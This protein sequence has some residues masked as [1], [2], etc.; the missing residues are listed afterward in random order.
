MVFLTKIFLVSALALAKYPLLESVASR[1]STADTIKMDVVKITRLKLLGKER[2]SEGQILVKK[3]GRLRWDTS[4][5]NKA[6]VLL[7]GKTI[8]LVDYPIDPEDKITVLKAANPKKSQPQTVVAFLLGRGHI[9]K[10][11][12]VEGKPKLE[13][14]VASYKLK[15][16]RSETQLKNLFIRISEN[17]KT[18]THMI[19]ED[20]LDNETEL[21]FKNIE[22]NLP[23]E[24]KQFVF[25]PPK[26]ADV[27]NID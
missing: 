17:D 2:T 1:Y 9:S 11:Y 18:I 19:F 10:N 13:N 14:G 5:P 8:W 12:S 27:T 23:V 4:K 20:N 3:T 15:S 26:N 16:K 6:L 7:D 25:K 21:N 24:D 22:F